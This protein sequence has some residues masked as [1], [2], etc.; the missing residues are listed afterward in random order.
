MSAEL[1]KTEWLP[2]LFAAIDAKDVDAFLGFLTEGATFR[3]GSAPAVAGRDAIRAAL[4]EFFGSIQGLRH[5]I[6]RVWTGAD[7]I[8]CEGNVVYTRLDGREVAVPF[9]DVFDLRGGKIFAYK[10]YIDATPLYAE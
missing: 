4:D 3:F 7:T 6:D 8:V 10:I 5:S 9:A 2:E 1:Q